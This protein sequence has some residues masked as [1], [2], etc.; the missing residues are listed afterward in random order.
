MHCAGSVARSLKSIRP[1][2]RGIRRAAFPLKCRSYRLPA[3]TLCDKLFC[4]PVLRRF[5][6][7]RSTARLAGYLSRIEVDIGDRVSLG[8][9]I[10]KIEVPELLDQYREAEAEMAAVQ[11]D[12]GSA[13]AEF[14]S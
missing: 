12:L 9:L 8:Q 3:R 10:A 1:R 2:L 5:T 6:E 14:E 7:R 4:R 11:A 13:D